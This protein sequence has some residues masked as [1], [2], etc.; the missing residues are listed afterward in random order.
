MTYAENRYLSV[1]ELGEKTRKSQVKSTLILK[2]NKIKKIIL[3]II[4]FTH[5]SFLT[6]PITKLFLH[7]KTKI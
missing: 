2:Q 5:S 4:N 7:G 1:L 3:K 6:L